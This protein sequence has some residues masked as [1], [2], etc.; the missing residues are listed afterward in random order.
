MNNAHNV[1]NQL[2]IV[3]LVDSIADKNANHKFFGLKNGNFTRIR[4]IVIGDNL[5]NVNSF[6]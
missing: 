2:I 1:I 6:C 3:M 4:F 5:Y